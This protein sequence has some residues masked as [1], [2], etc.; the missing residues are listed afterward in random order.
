MISIFLNLPVQSLVCHVLVD[1]GEALSTRQLKNL[2]RVGVRWRA[3]P[4][5]G[6]SAHSSRKIRSTL[7]PIELPT[8]S[9]LSTQLWEPLT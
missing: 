4:I 2:G 3:A 8:S 5:D 9:F 6:P 7:R 1:R